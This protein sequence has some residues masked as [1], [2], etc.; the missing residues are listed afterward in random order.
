V[1]EQSAVVT[2]LAKGLAAEC[3]DR[4]MRTVRHWNFLFHGHLSKFYLSAALCTVLS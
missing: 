4:R 1:A 3:T 2:K